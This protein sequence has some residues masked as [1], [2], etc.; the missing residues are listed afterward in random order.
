M[1]KYLEIV[2]RKVRGTDENVFFL[3]NLSF[4]TMWKEILPRNPY[5]SS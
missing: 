3:K 1:T 4:I 2:A 5:Q